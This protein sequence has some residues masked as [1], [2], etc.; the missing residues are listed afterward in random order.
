MGA[1]V[2][3]ADAAREAKHLAFTAAKVTQTAIE[4]SGICNLQHHNFSQPGSTCSQQRPRPEL[5]PLTLARQSSEDDWNELGFYASR[6]HA[7]TIQ[8]ENVQ[9]LSH[10]HFDHLAAFNPSLVRIPR[11]IV[12][13]L[14]LKYPTAKYVAS[15]RHS[16]GQCH[17]FE[18]LYKLAAY[19]TYGKYKSTAE[20]PGR[21]SSIVLLDRHFC[22]IEIARQVFVDEMD[23]PN[24]VGW[25]AEDVRLLLYD[26][27]ILATAVMS[28]EAGKYFQHD[29]KQRFVVQELIP[30]IQSDIFTARYVAAPSEI[31]PQLMNYTVVSNARN[32]GL[33]VL[34]GTLM[35]LTF[36][37]LRAEMQSYLLPLP[38]LP[39]TLPLLGHF[40]KWLHN[41]VNPLVIEHLNM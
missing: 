1:A 14:K 11:K 27:R 35:F 29:F 28:S 31:Y 16:W 2:N 33:L 18:A 10:L 8:T 22:I 25:L 36:L 34:D 9:T 40:G 23:R 4:K 20:Q 5:G 3:A 26:N 32:L 13:E 19:V 37:G 30:E 15:I 12:K 24:A 38:E 21:H 39:S 7:Q 17:R 6:F 41:N